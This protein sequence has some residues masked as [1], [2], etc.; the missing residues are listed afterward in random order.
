MGTGSLPGG[1]TVGVWIW[2][3]TPHLAQRLTSTA[4]ILLPP[5]GPSW[6]LLGW[7]LPLPLPLT[8]RYLKLNW[9]GRLKPLWLSNSSARSTSGELNCWRRLC[10]AVSQFR[11]ENVGWKLCS[12]VNDRQRAFEDPPSNCSHVAEVNNLIASVQNRIICNLIPPV[13][14]A[15]LKFITGVQNLWKLYIYIYVFW[16]FPATWLNWGPKW[17]ERGT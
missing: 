17:M 4:I 13:V 14:R 3:S 5:P 9:A 11:T 12:P 6:P 2:P 15:V 1:K 8:T 7:T 16:S 10:S